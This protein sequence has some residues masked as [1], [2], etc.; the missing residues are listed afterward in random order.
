[1]ELPWDAGRSRAQID[2]MRHTSTSS[3]L[4]LAACSC[5]ALFLALAG[6][7]TVTADDSPPGR[8]EVRLGLGAAALIEGSATEAALAFSSPLG[9][10]WQA[11]IEIGHLHASPRE[12][13][14][15]LQ[16]LLLRRY[17]AP[18]S[19]VRPYW[20]LGAG[21]FMGSGHWSHDAGVSA[22]VGAGV[23][24]FV[25]KTVFFAPEVRVGYVPAARLTL[26]IGYSPERRF[27]S[28]GA[29]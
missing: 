5:G 13:G 21:P 23:Q 20:L 12:N 22:T 8:Y 2:I 1:L 29:S 25:S 3:F 26:A 19:R 14:N 16:V 9:Q 18:S 7:R 17:G 4:R 27:S 6:V 24:L 15:V 10:R 11:G 28:A